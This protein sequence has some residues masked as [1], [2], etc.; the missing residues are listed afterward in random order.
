MKK[1][2]TKK[3]TSPKYEVILTKDE[4]FKVLDSVIQPIPSKAKRPKT[5]KKETSV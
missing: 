1:K 5:E 4:F 2:Q 3:T